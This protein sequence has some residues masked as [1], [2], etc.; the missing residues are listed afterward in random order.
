MAALTQSYHIDLTAPTDDRPFFF[1]Q[2]V[3]TD[4]A[5]IRGAR[6]AE[7]GVIRG[8]LAA[9]K[10]IGVIVLLSA[11]LVLITM[12]LPSLPAVRRAQASL[13]WFGTLYFALIGLG[14]M[15]IEIGIIQRVSLFSGI[16]FTTRDWPVQ[17]HSFHRHRQPDLGTAAAR[18]SG[19]AGGVVGG[20]VRV[21][22][23]LS[24]WFPAMVGA[25]E[26]HSL[27]VRVVVSLAAIVPSGVLMGFGFP[28][29]M[30]LANLV[31]TRP[32]PW[33]WA[34]NG[35]A[36]VLA[37][38]IAVGTS[39]AF[40]INA[41]L[42]IGAGC[43][44]LLAPVSVLLLRITRELAGWASR[45]RLCRIG[46]PHGVGVAAARPPRTAICG[47]MSKLT[48]FPAD[49]K[50]SPNCRNS[51]QGGTNAAPAFARYHAACVAR[52]GRRRAAVT[53]GRCHD[54]D[55]LYR[56]VLRRVRLGRRCQ[57]EDVPV[58]PGLHQ[59]KGRCARQEVRTG[60]VRRQAAAG[61]GT[62]RAEER[63]RP[64]PAV[65]HVL[66]RLQCRLGADRRGEQAQHPQSR[67]PHSAAQ[68]RPAGHRA[69]QRAMQLLAFPLRRQRGDA[70][71]GAD[72]VAAA[73]GE[74]G[75]S[76]E[77]GLPVRPVD[78]EGHQAV[79]R[80]SIAPTSR[81]SRTSSSR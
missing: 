41:S 57:P 44:L 3:L 34:I 19:K 76:A 53:C 24:V 33:F 5:S 60:D 35:S 77:P 8:N 68:L 69:D 23:L 58:H 9:T 51:G 70:R 30:R 54:Q 63:H 7:D 62:D 45:R 81:S 16:R 52:T 73:V 10:T 64:E 66:R 31:D 80:R 61:R 11:I 25:F 39:I 20:F 22:I 79:P 49:G 67:Q 1:N 78:R 46:E 71:G 59:C 6:N 40:S 2:L 43:Y 75:L 55:R 14:F 21:V 48:C 29:G 32:T 72:Q 74:V 36:G 56:S 47:R 13:A 4:W 18:H 17:H 50:A 38:S 37:A 42:W 26:G 28:T 27:V 12:V 15:F 65:R